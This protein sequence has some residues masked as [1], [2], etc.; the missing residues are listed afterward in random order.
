MIRLA[1]DH[2][3]HPEDILD[4]TVTGQEHVAVYV[5]VRLSWFPDPQPHSIYDTYE[6]AQE[7]AEALSREVDRARGRR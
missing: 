5:N 2:W 1:S 7:A 4:I 3:V 6:Q